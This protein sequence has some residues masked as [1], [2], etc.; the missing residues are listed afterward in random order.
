MAYV[1]AHQNCERD[2]DCTIVGDCGPNADFTAISV[3]AEAEGMRLMTARCGGAY[4]GVVP[5]AVCNAGVCAENY[6]E[7]WGCC[8]CQEPDDAGDIDSGNADSGF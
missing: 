6:D 3:G 1:V 5:S 4:D 8:G 7:P 2:S